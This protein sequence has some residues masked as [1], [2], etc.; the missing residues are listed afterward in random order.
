MILAGFFIDVLLKGVL[1]EIGSIVV[2]LRLWRVLKIIEELSAGAEEQ[3]EPL[4]EHLEELEK[5]NHE[6][7]LQ[8]AQ[9]QEQQTVAA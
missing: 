3:I 9:L 8:L 2:V 5:E 6:L 7:K 1:E 4:Q